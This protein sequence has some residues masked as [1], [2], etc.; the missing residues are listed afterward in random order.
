MREKMISVDIAEAI[1][2]NYKAF[3]KKENEDRKIPKRRDGL[4][5]VSR[6]VL[7][8]SYKCGIGTK[9]MKSAVICGDCSGHY[10]PHSDDIIYG[11]LVTLTKSGLYETQGN[12]GS[13]HGM[14]PASPAAK[15][16]T[17]CKLTKEATDMMF[18]LI[19]F[20]PYTKNNLNFEEPDFLP[21]KYPLCYFQSTL[22]SGIGFGYRGDYPS[23]KLED[24]KQR[25][26]WLIKQRKTEP[27]IEPYYGDYLEVKSSKDELKRLLTTGE[28]S[29]TFVPK[30]VISGPKTISIL[31]NSMAGNFK[32]QVFSVFDDKMLKAGQVGIVDRSTTKTEVVITFYGRG[33]NPKDYVKLLSDRLSF[34]V[35]YNCIFVNDDRSIE[36][37]SVDQMLVE[38]YQ[39]YKDLFFKKIDYD[40]QQLQRKISDMDIIAK[41]RPFLRRHLGR[42]VTAELS[43][44]ISDLSRNASIPVEDI[45]RVIG[46]YSIKVLLTCNTDSTALQAKVKETTAKKTEAEVISHY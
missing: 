33:I 42:E 36:K 2:S 16:Y 34:A 10:H 14:S 45:S 15:R 39:Q 8:S 13:I 28:G 30:V 5:P 35:S 27:I 18:G 38:I 1:R 23:Y 37:V 40:V 31:A 17:D 22:N 4:R 19:D 46:A 25:L 3:G 32:K 41:I 26:F 43:S 44:I 29:I 6:R 7:Y 21:T 9:S 12:F 11:A 20:V 24:L